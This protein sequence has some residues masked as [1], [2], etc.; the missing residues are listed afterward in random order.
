MKDVYIV[1]S[2][3]GEWED[4]SEH[5][6]YLVYDK[7]YAE[8]LLKQLQDEEQRFSQEYTLVCQ[9]REL[10]EDDDL[11]DLWMSKVEDLYFEDFL[12]EPEKYP[13]VLSRFTTQQQKRLLEYAKVNQRWEQLGG[14]LYENV[15]Y[16]MRH[17]TLDCDGKMTY[18]I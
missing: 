6:Q 18:V 2:A 15:A 11:G 16:H 8:T 17:Y 12:N 1:Y 10:F 5:I 3:T 7:H 4:Y 13:D 14:Y 9:Q